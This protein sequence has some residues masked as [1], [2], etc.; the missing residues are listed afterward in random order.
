MLHWIGQEVL[1]ILVE[2]VF[3][4]DIEKVTTIEYVH[5]YAKSFETSQVKAY[6][7]FR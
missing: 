6:L 7:K 4:V 5:I 3:I 2:T 1:N